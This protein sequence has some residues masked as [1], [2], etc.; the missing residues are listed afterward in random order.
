MEGIMSIE[1]IDLT[2]T[3]IRISECMLN[4]TSDLVAYNSTPKTGL[5][6]AK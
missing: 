1:N 3:T 5:E 6:S 2:I 4:Q